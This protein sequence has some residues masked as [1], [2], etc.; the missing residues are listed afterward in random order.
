MSRFAA[1][2]ILSRG[3]KTTAM[4]REH[5]TYRT[6]GGKEVPSVTQVLG[7]LDKGEGLL[8]W[9][10]DCGRQGIS[11]RAVRDEAGREGSIIH[12]LIECSLKRA[13]PDLLPSEVEVV[14]TKILPAFMAW[15]KWD[16][17]HPNREL[18]ASEV[19]LVSDAWKYGGTLDY[20]Y[21]NSSSGVNLVDFKTGSRVYPDMGYQL[22][23]YCQLW[24]EHHPDCPVDNAYILRLDKE[25]GEYNFAPFPDLD[26][27]FEVFKHCLALWNLTSI[28]VSEPGG[29]NDRNK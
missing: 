22:A 3:E 10:Y 7:V 21:R 24:G 1:Y 6:L 15:Q 20:I 4:I 2:A 23:A 13:A 19:S 12:Y 8:N 27:D 11:W 16:R 9:V 28:E 29:R 25:T 26:R 18:I 17:E 5:P 14:R